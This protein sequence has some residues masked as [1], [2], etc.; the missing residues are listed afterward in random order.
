M[1][2][3]CFIAVII[4][5]TVSL[6]LIF[7]AIKY[8]GDDITKFGKEKI[9][10]LA[11]EKINSDIAK[12]E[13]SN[14]ADSLQQIVDNYFNDSSKVDIEAQLEGLKEFGQNIEAIINDSQIDSAEYAFLKQTIKNNERRKKN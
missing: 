11:H 5:L 4:T 2:K 13:K 3:G 1:K 12:I 6:L 7:Y 10:N 9:T 8:F 14:Y